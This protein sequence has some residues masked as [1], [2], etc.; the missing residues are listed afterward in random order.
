VRR[1]EGEILH[2]LRNVLGNRRIPIGGVLDLHANF[3]Q[4]MA[5]NADAL[6]AYRE[7]PHVDAKAAAERAA[8]LL[9]RLLET[10]R[11]ATTVWQHPPILWPPTAR[12]RTPIR[13]GRWRPRHG[14]SNASTTTFLA[15]T[16]LP[17]SP[18]PTFP[19]PV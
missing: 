14:R 9:D 5:E 16:C 18:S 11:R 3:T 15:S 12:V 4:D 7:N 17:A 2:R 6:L 1:R 19:T 10:G 8:E 13:C